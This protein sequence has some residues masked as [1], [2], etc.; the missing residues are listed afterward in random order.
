MYNQLGTPENLKQKIA[1]PG[2]GCHPIGCKLFSGAWKDIELASFSFAEAKL[3][4]LPI[5]Q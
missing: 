1:F 4:L 2:A 5:G 3:E